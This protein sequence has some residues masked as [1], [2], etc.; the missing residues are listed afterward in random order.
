MMPEAETRLT[1]SLTPIELATAA[2]LALPTVILTVIGWFLPHLSVVAALG[3]VPLGVVAYRHRLR[4]LLAASFAAAVLSFLVAGPGTISNI[5]EC[6]A[7][8]ALVGT[9]RRRRWHGSLVLV[10]ALVVSAVLSGVSIALL[11]A[12]SGLRKLT[13]EQIHN[14]AKGVQ[15]LL[16]L[17]PPHGF[18]PGLTHSAVH[19]LADHLWVLIVFAPVLL[20][21]APIAGLA[22]LINPTSHLVRLLAGPVHTLATGLVRDWWIAVVVG[23]VLSTAGYALVAWFVL[24]PVVARLRLVS[25]ANHLDKSLEGQ[26]PGPVPVTLGRVSYRYPASNRD[27]LDGVS[28][29]I[30][31]DAF[32]ALVGD[33]GSG[34]STLARI[35]AGQPP[36]SGTVDRPGAA[37]L[38]RKHG[39]ALIM[40]HPETQV[41]GVRVADDVV[42]GLDDI[43]G[44]NV[45][46]LLDRVGLAGMEERETSGLS[47]GELQRL[48][49]AAALARRP[50]LL[51][52]DE[53]TAMVDEDGRHKLVD[54]LDGLHGDGGVAVVHASHR[55]EEAA[56]ASRR[57][58]LDR[59]LLVAPEAVRRDGVPVVAKAAIAG[60]EPVAPL[61]LE[62][63]DVS[64]TY[65]EGT[66]WAQQALRNINLTIEAGEG[67]LVVGDNG[68]GKSTLAWVMAGLLQPTEGECLLGDAPVT[69]QVGAVGLAFQHARLQLQR[70]LIGD[71]VRAAGA[72]DDAAVVAALAA[73]GL[74]P[75]DFKDRR[76]DQL[77]GGQ[78]RRVAIAGIL[79][80]RP[81][82]L[83]LDEPLAGL[84]EPSRNGLIGV[85]ASLRY[86]HGMTVV[87]ISH[88]LGGVEQVCDRTVRLEGG[89]LLAESS[90]V[91]AT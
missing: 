47:G 1:G 13:L 86:E 24:A 29:S 2:V 36:T 56:R 21:V 53:S 72:A 39:S 82:V 59:G 6:A 79:A 38:G 64:H 31:P 65:S 30:E 45:A 51:I 63:V 83:V 66:P 68:S 33:N 80:R 42:W 74:D 58:R 28:L 20:L 35:L 5:V 8:G 52:S 43:S 44:V 87:I 89:H 91:V 25:P 27:A 34:K 19:A 77:S 76:I 73:V 26:P 16:V 75:D 49:V 71:D 22:A 17:I 10:G 57:I 69:G 23:V 37:G 90:V 41:L 18:A 7:I 54:L 46:A 4:A 32:V 15:R 14:V 61:S 48:A 88:D 11:E 50:R 85:L 40:Q 84:D 12:F 3:V 9:I 67:L 81:S 60:S 62:V 55:P 78:Q 70:Q